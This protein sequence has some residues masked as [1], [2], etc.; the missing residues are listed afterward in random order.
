VASQVVI[1]V[2]GPAG[3]GKTTTARLLAAGVPDGV[4]IA[5]DALKEFIVTRSPDRPTGVA[6]AAAGALAG[7][8]LAAGYQRIVIDY[9]FEEPAHLRRFTQALGPAV[10]VRVFTLWAPLPVVLDRE[11]HR[12]GRDRLGSRVAEC[13]GVL[14]AHL[15]G[16]G[17]LVD[18]DRSATEVVTDLERRLTAA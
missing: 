12:P 18:A 11:A 16:L 1:V 7:A 4:C 3:V 2:N 13:W 15:D 17:V 10:P 14:A 5:G 6:Y 8:Y 9:V